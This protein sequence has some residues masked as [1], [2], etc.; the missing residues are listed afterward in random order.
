ML[1]KKILIGK[2]RGSE[3]GFICKRVKISAGCAFR[4]NKGGGGIVE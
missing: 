2:G 3:A 1:L 4:V